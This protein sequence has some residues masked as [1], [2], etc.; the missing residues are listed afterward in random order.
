MN[1]E[2]DEI[3]RRVDIVSLVSRELVLKRTGKNFVGLCPFHPD[4]N[5]SMTVNP[6]TGRYKCWSCGAGGDIF[7]WVMARQNVDFPEAM[8]ILAKD[9]G[10]ELK[11][12]DP[13]AAR[14]RKVR[15]GVM[16]AA[17]QFYRQAYDRSQTAQTYVSSR[18]LTPAVIS[19]WE[20]GFAP[21]QSEALATQL[22]RD[23]YSLAEAKQLFLVDSDAS[24]G[25]YDKFRGRL[26]FPIRDERGTLVAFGGR[27][28]GAGQ[29]KYINSSDTAIYRKSRVL[30]GMNQAKQTIQDSRVALLT[31]GYLDVIACHA[32]GVTNAVASL[33]TALSEDQADLLKRWCDH[34]VILYDSDEAGQKAAERALGVLATAG[35]K[36]SVA[37]L[38]DGED[39]DSI[40]RTQGSAGI[41]QA[42]EEAIPPIDFLLRRLEQKHSV[43]SDAFW[44]AVPGV[45]A[46][47]KSE[48][49][50][51]RY[52]VRL[53]PQYPGVSD[54]M[55]AVKALRAMAL[56][57]RRK[58]SGDSPSSYIMPVG[59]L[60][61]TLSS[62]ELAIFAAFLSEDLR[63][64]AYLFSRATIL[65]SSTDAV[66][67]STAIGSAFPDGPPEGPLVQWIHRIEPEE[68]Q[69]LLGSLVD[70]L[71][72]QLIDATVLADAIHHLK[73]KAA[74]RNEHRLKSENKADYFGELRRRKGLPDHEGTGDVEDSFDMHF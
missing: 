41:R 15:E 65:F 63:R 34:V 10:I 5:P 45:L 26:M 50:L 9:A 67:L 11:G 56:R 3:R 14:Q 72:G 59:G 54:P 35:L 57:H 44:E 66:R 17:L 49:E 30:Y 70:D 52:L 28:I 8:R 43:Q 58:S 33:G 7:N 62:S 69:D 64:Q 22:K 60:K 46:L 61:H 23:G 1:D 21:D 39:P 32:A 16:E 2:R 24:G 4:K 36:S 29:P 74:V 53:A 12:Q 48:L 18:E 40:R 71:R 42:V 55:A 37:I 19:Q 6:D 31:E 47:T 25:F 68:L 73:E 27:I 20:I 38:A 13:D 51:D